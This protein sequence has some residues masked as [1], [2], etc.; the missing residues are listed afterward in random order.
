MIE[1]RSALAAHPM[2]Q[3]GY[4]PAPPAASTPQVRLAERRTSELLQISAFAPSLD[5][6]G[7]RLATLLGL[8]LPAANRYSGDR[9]QSLRAI[10]PGIWQITGDAAA[11]P[12]APTLRAALAGV[13]TVVDLGHARTTLQLSGPAATRVLAQHCSLDLSAA[14][15]PLGSATQT[16]FGHIGMGLAHTDAA[17]TFELMVFRG[18][19]EFVFESLAASAKEFGLRIDV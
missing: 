11:V 3:P 1:R 6:A 19:A 9:H 15:F 18:Y 2:L 16:R 12:A 4:R 17:P 5:E 10:G 13:A 7:A 8:A 14:R